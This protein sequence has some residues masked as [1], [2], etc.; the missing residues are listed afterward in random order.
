MTHSVSHTSSTTDHDMP[1][2]DAAAS[3]FTS[4]PGLLSQWNIELA[5]FYGRRMQAYAM[6]P[7]T[8]MLCVS[9]EDVVDAQED[10]S[11]TL[12]ADYRAAAGKLAEA[13]GCDA[14]AIPSGDRAQAYAA[15][16]LKA[17][18]DARALLDQAQAQ[19]RRIIAEAEAQIAG[20]HGAAGKTKAA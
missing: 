1:N 15:S 5:S 19:A 12:V 6:L 11:R 4:W 3:P 17:Q 7:V 13:A 14:R 10:F 20:K 16:L 8:L 2:R 18:D 9:P